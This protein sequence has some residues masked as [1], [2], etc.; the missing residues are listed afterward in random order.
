M[1]LSVHLPGVRWEGLKL[2]RVGTKPG[3]ALDE[4]VEDGWI[5]SGFG[6][7]PTTSHSAHAR[8]VRDGLVTDS[9]NQKTSFFLFIFCQPITGFVFANAAELKTICIYG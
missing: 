9:A 2:P 6:F 8:V 4:A 5:R 1:N 3:P 7:D